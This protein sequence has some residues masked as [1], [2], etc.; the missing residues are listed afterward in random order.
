MLHSV[1]TTP[2]AF[3]IFNHPESTRQVFEAIRAARPR[4]LFI[5]ADAP[6]P[7]RPDDI[8]KCAAAKAIVEEVDWPCEV[9]KNYSDENMGCGLRPAS[10]ID[11]VFKQVETAIILEHDCLPHPT[12]F[13]YC[14]ELLEYYQ[15]NSN[16]MHISGNNYQFGRQRGEASYFY[17]RH[18][19]IWGWATWRRAWQHYNYHIAQWPDL[20]STDWLDT[21]L[22]TP[23]AIAYWQ[24]IFDDM[25]SGEIETWDYQW[26]FA[27][28]QHQGLSILPQVDLVANIGFHA[29]AVN[30]LRKNQYAN[31]LLSEMKF[32][33]HHPSEI[34]RNRHAD[35]FVQ[36]S[37]FNLDIWS[38][39]R[40]KLYWDRMQQKIGAFL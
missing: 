32:P 15:D 24:K 3:I 27:C 18:T 26:T 12:F 1:C 22:D 25:Y 36:R 16:I 31:V 23:D 33:L 5:I 19:H 20:R 35:I 40:R 9:L 13:P 4:Q 14:T 37:K 29:E 39:L 2:V 34:I 11:W 28:W 8:P 10:G 38:R 17:S 7:D 6:R 30:T 21:L